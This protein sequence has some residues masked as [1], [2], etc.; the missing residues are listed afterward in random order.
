[1]HAGDV[2]VEMLVKYGVEYV[3]GLPGGQ[4]APLYDAIYRRPDQIQHILMRDERSAAYAADAYARVTGRIGVCDATVGPGATKLPSGLAEAKHSSIPVLAILSDIDQATLPLSDYGAA[5]QAL[6]Q[7]RMVE[8]LIKWGAKVPVVEILPA[9]LRNAMRQATSGRPG[10]VVLDIPADVFKADCSALDL[11][12][13]ALARDGSY[14]PR[15]QGPDADSVA[16]ASFQLIE[17]ERP[18][19][20]AGGGVHNS[21]ATDELLRLAERLDIPVATTWSGKGALPETHPLSLG[22][23]GAMG[24]TCATEIVAEADVVFLIGNKSGQ[25]STFA[26][27]LPRDDQIVIHLD[28]DPAEVGKVFHTAVGLVGDARTGLQMILGQVFPVER[29]EWL[30]RVAEARADWQAQL[31]AERGSDHVPVTPQRVMGELQKLWGE[32]DL[33]VCDASFVSGWG[34]AFLQLPVAGRRA[35]FP[36]GIAG[37]GWALPAAI[38]ARFGHPEGTVVCLAGDGGFA[39]SVAELSTLVKY[40]LKV[41]SIVLNN[42]ALSWIKWNQRMTWGE[43]YQSSDFP[44]VDF[45]AVARGFGCQGIS[46]TQPDELAAALESAFASDGPVVI[47]VKTEEWETP[48]LAYRAAIERPA[49]VA[50]TTAHATRQ[51]HH[52]R[53]RE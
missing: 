33:L 50:A 21:G 39:Y 29:P 10:P 41:V 12:T 38:G 35:L 53:Q 8:P 40:N 11:D 31:D 42:R 16:L 23:L 51:P 24:T 46:V 17:A 3:F 26:W 32:D 22:L 13:S 20:V 7:L 25:N 15:R 37:L 45:A 27:T 43:R 47:D 36:R 49:E 28:I 30:A 34:G 5:S 9:M 18:V 4:T 19:I 2:L 48:I 14:P 44:D 6:D 52:P 1:M